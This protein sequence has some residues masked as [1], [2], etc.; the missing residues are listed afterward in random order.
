VFTDPSIPLS[1]RIVYY[2]FV[3]PGENPI[4]EGTVD[5]HPAGLLA[6]TYA[7]ETYTSDTAADLRTAVEIVLHDERNS[8][9]EPEFEAEI[10]DV[11]FSNGHAQVLLQGEYSGEYSIS[12][13]I[14]SL[15]VCAQFV[16]SR[17]LSLLTVFANPAVQT[18]AVSLNE[19]TIAN[20][21]SI[22]PKPV[23]TRAEVEAYL[24]ENAYVSP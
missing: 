21:C 11:T 24:K 14:S 1:E 13:P 6:P 16:G 22:D 19:D 12:E 9:L 23:L 20:L 2:Y 18:A 17:M 7:N 3:K 5:V 8:W 15:D 4:P 10:V